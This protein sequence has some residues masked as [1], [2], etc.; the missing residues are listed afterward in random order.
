MKF[1]C[2][3]HKLE[4]KGSIRQFNET[5]LVKPLALASF[6]VFNTKLVKLCR[7]F[8]T[9]SAVA[10]LI[11][12]DLNMKRTHSLEVPISNTHTHTESPVSEDRLMI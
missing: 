8:K 3:P 4:K 9:S 10:K 5:P 6:P 7:R 1:R 2:C 11:C 12:K